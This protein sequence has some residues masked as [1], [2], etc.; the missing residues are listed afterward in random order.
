MGIILKSIQNKYGKHEHYGR[1]NPPP[2]FTREF[3]K[4]QSG[5]HR[6]PRSGV[7]ARRSSRAIKL[8]RSNESSQRLVREIALQV[9]ERQLSAAVVAIH[10]RATDVG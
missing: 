8:F 6:N 10:R 9:T 1:K 2:E 4:N 3:V 7:I 5:W